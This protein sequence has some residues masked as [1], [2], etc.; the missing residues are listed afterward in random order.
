VAIL[1]ILAAISSTLFTGITE[2]E[3]AVAKQNLKS[4]FLIEADYH[5]EY[6]L[7][8]T[9]GVGNTKD[10]NKNLFEGV[11]TLDEKSNYDYSIIKN[12]IG[13][14][15]YAKPKKSDLKVYCVDHNNALSTSC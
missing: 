5:S 14:K 13:Y 15:A 6:N 11:N 12:G 1:S 3:E 9:T 4:I 10:I 7:Y 8:L 2:T